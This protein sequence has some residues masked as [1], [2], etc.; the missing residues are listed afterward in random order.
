[1]TS[2]YSAI[3]NLP[4][5]QITRTRCPFP[6]N[7]FIT[8]TVTSNHYEVFYRFSQ[9]P[10]PKT[11]PISLP[12]TVLYSHNYSNFEI[13]FPYK[14]FAQTQLK[15]TACIADEAC[16]PSRCLTIDSLLLSCA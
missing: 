12:T 10:I 7:G 9:L 15:I 3:A 1:M 11:W 5:S 4:T 2:N 6:G 16:L 8:G 14:L 13:R